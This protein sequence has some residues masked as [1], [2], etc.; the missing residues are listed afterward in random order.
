MS[1]C[2]DRRFE[3]M[4][5]AYEI[6]ILPEDEKRELE[7]HVL[8]CEFCLGELKQFKEAALHIR[9]DEN[10]RQTIREIV[11]SNADGQSAVIRTRRLWSTIVPM[12]A[13]AA[14]IIML[15]LQP[16]QIEIRPRQE[17]A[18]AENRLAIIDFVNYADPADSQQLGK[19]IANLLITDLSES[20]FVQV[21]SG[22][23][24][25]DQYEQ[26]EYAESIKIDD[27]LAI[28]NA[29]KAGASWILTGSILR[30]SPQLEITSRIID[31]ASG[32]IIGSQ[33]LS[34]DS[35]STIFSMVDQL[36]TAVKS[37]L[38]VPDGARFEA[39]RLIAD[40]TTH[41]AEAY[42]YY[43]DG[44]DYYRKHLNT[45]ARRSF[46]Q[47]LEYDSTFAMAYYYLTLIK[48]ASMLDGAVKY[49]HKASEKD[50]YYI[51]ALQA[52]RDHNRELR[53]S[54]LGQLIDRYPDE[55]YA[56]Q[57]MGNLKFGW[58]QYDEAI[59]YY[60]RILAI[61]P[62]NK[63]A[64]NLLAYS[65]SNQGRLD[66]A[67]KANDK[68]RSIAP[69]EPNPYDSRG[70]LFARHG[71]L[72]SSIAAYQKAL[73][74]KPD[75]PPSLENLGVNHIFKGEYD[76]A[77]EYFHKMASAESPSVRSQGR[78]YL[79]LIPLNQG[80][81]KKSLEVIDDCM[82]ADRL[83]GAEAEQ[84][85]KHVIKG[86]IYDG[87]NKTDAA[88]SEIRQSLPYAG[89]KNHLYYWI[90]ARSGNSEEAR[91]DL[92]R[93]RDTLEVSPGVMADYYLAAGA[94]DFADGLYDDAIANL[95]KAE[96]ISRSF[97]ADYLLG[98]AYL[99][100]ERLEDAIRVF[101]KRLSIYESYRVC[102]GTWSV[103]MHYYLGL[104]YEGAKRFDDAI[105]QYEKFLQ[106]WQNAD[107][108]I[109]ELHD[110]RVR[111][112]RLKSIG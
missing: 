55:T 47:V 26:V 66:E 8:E 6:G 71:M 79:A 80:K 74:I 73:E 30:T 28:E 70:E 4:L 69:N 63:E 33:S 84:G 83:E 59:D 36:T 96:E 14:V 53:E 39:D 11:D 12:A 42:R 23:R 52:S 112:A 62:K 22:Q 78:Y 106:I 25:S 90:M 44:L 35:A 20:H 9:H 107:S 3:K 89:G 24:L 48:D 108:E 58:G 15:V 64:Y 37:D 10:T 77:A 87:M 92:K 34:G 85:Y 43:L 50:G 101:E 109:E 38:P 21:I 17:A 51:R 60:E 110:S 5:F 103:K 100:A 76:E 27:K 46:E 72:D 29:K 102:R 40:F 97:P 91:K 98:Q 54:I 75:F 18:A 81:I 16:W 31:I 2:K 67:I 95:E 57:L 32:D 82:A 1:G 61:D 19:I 68:Y 86:V 41:S 105:T 56:L 45:N 93:N 94:V 65:Y 13:A 111:L 7:L 99:K 49:M 104:A 88:L